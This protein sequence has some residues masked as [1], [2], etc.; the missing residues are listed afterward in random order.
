MQ[1][2]TAAVS[3]LASRKLL[4]PEARAAPASHSTSHN[5]AAGSPQSPL[6]GRQDQS[7]L[8]GHGQQQVAATWVG[9]MPTA[10]IGLTANTQLQ[11]LT[12]GKCM[13]LPGSPTRQFAPAGA[14]QSHAAGQ[15]HSHAA[16]QGHTLEAGQRPRNSPGLLPQG[17]RWQHRAEVCTESLAALQ[18]AAKSNPSWAHTTLHSQ[19]GTA[20]HHG[21]L[22]STVMLETLGRQKQA[23]LLHE[24]SKSCLKQKGRT[25]GSGE[26][27]QEGCSPASPT[28]HKWVTLHQ[29]R[30]TLYVSK[31]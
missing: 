16:G 9:Q 19:P 24:N 26:A 29:Q 4:F 14:G 15:G 23:L 21:F 7:Q 1:P 18:T 6:T 10:Q 5:P 17:N 20:E 2:A 12:V 30:A 28:S 25:G 22:A 31:C 8:H 13:Q 3:S 27:G 11:T